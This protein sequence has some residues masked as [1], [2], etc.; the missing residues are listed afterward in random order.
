MDCALLPGLLAEAT[1]HPQPETVIERLFLLQLRRR[2]RRSGPEVRTCSPRT[3]RRRILYHSHAYHGL[4]MGALAV[5]GS[6]PTFAKASVRSPG[7]HHGDSLRRS[8]RVGTEL[9]RGPDVAAFIVEPIQGKGATSSTRSV[10]ARLQNAVHAAR[11]ASP[12][13]RR[14]ADRTR[15]HRR[16]L[17]PSST[18]GSRSGHHHHLQGPFRR[19]RAGR[20][21]VDQ[22]QDP[23]RH[24][25]LHGARDG[26]LDDL[27]EP[28]PMAMLAGLA[29]LSV[30]DDE[31]IVEHA[32]GHG[33]R[34]ARASWKTSSL[35][36][37]SSS[38]W[39]VAGGR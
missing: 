23:S 8:R 24:L 20:G 29:T 13:L 17:P 9:K 3:G 38:T 15:S 5:N 1:D 27:Q 35:A 12:H 22:R 34:L 33:Q 14:G 21:D 31:H 16:V 7:R 25:Q 18:T 11:R 6:A 32:A 37:T 10:L 2:G 19:L 26:A 36:V 28:N 4:T 30:F 39:Y